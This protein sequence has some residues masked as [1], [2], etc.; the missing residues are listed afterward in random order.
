[1]ARKSPAYTVR[2]VTTK[3]T[4]V[5][6]IMRSAPFVRGFNEARTGVAMDYDA[7]TETNDQWAYERGRQFGCIFDGPLKKGHAI[8]LGAALQF[9][10]AVGS[11][12]IF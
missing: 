2:Q 12:A 5:K 6:G 1:M 3:Q 8:N 4:T 7:Y 9:S 10:Q 11:K